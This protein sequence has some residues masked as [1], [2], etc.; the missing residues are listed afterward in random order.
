ML[1]VKSRII[2]LYFYKMISRQILI[3]LSI[4]LLGGFQSFAQ[5]KT[6]KFFLD[7]YL[8]TTDS[9]NAVYYKI[10]S[11]SEI[12][13]SKTI[14]STFNM[15]GVIY[16]I[17]EYSD[18]NKHIKSGKS[19]TYHS[20][21]N[22]KSIINFEE[23]KFHDTLQTFYE[24]G[25]LRRLEIYKE[26][27]MLSGRCFGVNGNDTL[28]FPFEIMARYPGGETAMIQYLKNNVKYPKKARKKEIEGSV[29]INFLVNKS[30]DLVKLKIAKSVH[31]LLD[32]EALRVVSNMGKW[33][34]GERDGEKTSVYF[35]LPIKFRL[36]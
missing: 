25:K 32:E 19:V 29:H 22:F 18:Y 34:P 5:F 2:N 7:Q 27:K 17:E 15:F 13:S 23:G 11:P 26:G 31:P 1:I 24:S 3:I 30:G 6:Q 35:T 9:L 28:H 10:V 14:A 12:D 16:S 4:V 33:I 8:F 21:L 36:Q 20:N